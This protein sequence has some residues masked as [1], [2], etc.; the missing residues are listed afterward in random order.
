MNA[1][2]QGDRMAGRVMASGIRAEAF[3]LYA[4]TRLGGDDF[5]TRGS[6]LRLEPPRVSR[7][8]VALS[9]ADMANLLR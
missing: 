4:A 3:E 1:T 7:I 8:Q 9:Q 6:I 2:M 5:I